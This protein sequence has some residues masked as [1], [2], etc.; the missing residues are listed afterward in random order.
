MKKFWLIFLIQAL[1]FTTIPASGQGLH[2][3]GLDSPIGQRTT[4]EVFHNVRPF[5]SDSLVVR[6]GLRLESN[7][8]VDL[9]Y[10]CHIETGKGEKAPVIHLLMDSDAASRT[11]RVIWEGQRFIANVQ[12]PRD[13]LSNRWFP[14]TMVFNMD[15]GSIGLNV[16]DN[17]RS[18]GEIDLPRIMRPY[19]VFG[20]YKDLTDVSPFSI[21]DLELQGHNRQWIFPLG[22]DGGTKASCKG[23]VRYG[24]VVQP[25]W[26]AQDA[27]SWKGIF[28]NYSDNYQCAGYDPLTHRLWCFSR[29][30]ISY[31]SLPDAGRVDYRFSTP[32]PLTSTLG[33]SFVD[34]SDGVLYAYEMFY[35][36]Y[37]KQASTP[38]VAALHPGHLDWEPLCSE[39]FDIQFHHH[40]EFVDTSERRLLIYGGYSYKK[41]NGT[42]YSFSLDSLR[43]SAMPPVTGDSL[44]PRFLGAMGY[45][46]SSGLLYLFGGKGNESGDQIV[47]S[48]YLYTLHSVDPRTM[49]CRK[50]WQIPWSGENI[51]TGRNMV[52]DGTGNFYVVGYSESHTNTELNLYR[53]SME[54]G[55]YEILA[56]PIPFYSDRITCVAN[57]YYD[58]QIAK[59]IA[60]VEE[61]EDDVHS[62]VAA[63]VL[64]YP[65]RK[66]GVSATI[67]HRRIVLAWI[68]ALT[69]LLGASLLA[70]ISALR[71]RR[72]SSTDTPPVPEQDKPRPNSIL[73]FGG[74]TARDRNGADLTPQFTGKLRQ[75]FCMLLRRGSEGMSSRH[76]GSLLWPDRTESETKNVKGVTVNKLR[77]VLA[78][79]DGVSLVSREKRFYLEMEN[80]FW[81]DYAQLQKMLSDRRPDMDGVLRI[82][83]RGRFLTEETD[84]VYDKMKESEAALVEPVMISEMHRRFS[85]KQYQTCLA[86]ANILFTIDPLHGEA[87][88]YAVRSL[89]A[90]DK[91]EEAKA[92]YNRFITRYEK[93]YGEAWPE[94]YEAIS[95]VNS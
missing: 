66:A 69:L 9:G 17:W 45:D 41:Y 19:L 12:V 34:P 90:M 50:I 42:F 26:L 60:T 68:L 48:Q 77:K 95:N 85:Q 37:L 49:T 78:Q 91:P 20:R 5:V 15:D 84:P 59:M 28:S 35:P 67:R 88:S 1:L 27:G 16:A 51:V 93:D 22:E 56:D 70:V 71:R 79:M 6:F 46:V 40:N 13:S 43:W 3:R 7:Q 18:S 10:I 14:V 36:Y 80:P 87:L 31:V 75:M 86:C 30:S 47:G 73:L 64:D 54:D 39:A 25:S 4:L 82:L 2:F 29:D 65:P 53:F 24:R 61:S 94:S 89:Q 55:S 32:C 21:R 8:A 23:S 52:I 81:C 11:F 58:P 57:L 83:A 76:L 33:T 38:S 72:K 92:L 63:Y 62:H 74:V 44:W